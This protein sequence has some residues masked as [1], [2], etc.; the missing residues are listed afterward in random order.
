MMTRTP[1]EKSRNPAMVQ[2]NHWGFSFQQRTPGMANPRPMRVTQREP[3][4]IPWATVTTLLSLKYGWSC[5]SQPLFIPA[6]S[7][8]QICQIPCSTIYELGFCAKLPKVLQFG[9]TVQT[10]FGIHPQEPITSPKIRMPGVRM[11][12]RIHV[13]CLSLENIRRKSSG[14]VAAAAAAAVGSNKQN[15][16]TSDN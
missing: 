12:L 2:T 7:A 15:R 6:R 9:A 11:V 3:T 5:R 16:V 1:E 14:M 13:V 4:I 8:S 10:R